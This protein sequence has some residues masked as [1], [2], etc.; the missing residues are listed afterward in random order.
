MSVG[1]NRAYVFVVLEWL[2]Q[3]LRVGVEQI[4][5]RARAG[6]LNGNSPATVLDVGGDMVWSAIGVAGGEVHIGGT[7]GGVELEV[8]VHGGD[9]TSVGVHATC[10]LTGLDVA[11]D[12]GCHV[13]LVIHEACVEVGWS[14]GVGGGD[15][16]EAAREGVLEEVEHGEELPGRHVEVVTEPSAAC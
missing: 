2:V 3:E 1:G 11:P 10:C 16:G 5:L 13:F 12:H 14:V 4:G 8:R 9:F 7:S 6:L 15:L